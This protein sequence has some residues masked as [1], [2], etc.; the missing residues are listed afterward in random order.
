MKAEEYLPTYTRAELTDVI[1]EI[2][3]FSPIII[4]IVKKYEK[5]FKS[6]KK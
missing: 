4:L 2:S 5:N 1:Y 6:H 3:V